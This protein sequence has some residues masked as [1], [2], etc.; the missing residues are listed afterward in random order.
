MGEIVASVQRVTDIMAQISGA[1]QEQSA[2]I[3]QVN[4]TLAHMDESTQQNASLVEEASAAARAMEHQAS[5]LVDAVALFRLGEDG[6]DA[7]LAQAA[8]PGPSRTERTADTVVNFNP[9]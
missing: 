8:R 4:R 5:Q 7:L 9:R 1:S 2:G 3:D 6:V